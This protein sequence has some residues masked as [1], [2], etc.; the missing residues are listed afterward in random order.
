MINKIKLFLIIFFYIFTT[1]V[2]ASNLEKILINGNNRI[3]DDTIKMFSKIKIGE[4]INEI[5]LNNILKNLYETYYFED[6]SVQIENNNLIINVVEAKIIQDLN[7]KGIKSSKI[8]EEIRKNL[9][10]KPR[11]SFNNFLLIEDKRKIEN[12]LKNFGYY[13]SEVE[14]FITEIEDNKLNIDHEIT[15]GEKSKIKKISFIGNKI[16]KNNKLR[17]IIIS[18][19]YKFWKFISGKKFLN[20]EL[21]KLD[22]RLLKNFYLNKGYYNVEVNSSFAKMINN[23]EF[24]LIYNIDP[25]KKVYFNN[26]SLDIPKDFELK[27]FDEVTKILRKIKGEPY[28]LYTVEKILGLIEKITINEQYMSVKASVEEKITSDKLDLKFKIDETEKYYVK[29]INI[30]GNNVTQENV[31]RNQ[32][33]ID[34][35]DPFNSILQKKNNK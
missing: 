17:N 8:K 28:S 9:I 7:I 1:T 29:K 12:A 32:F 15:L 11:S 21:I 23:N 10:L 34:E 16:Y 30:Y 26:I 25:K 19:E 33:E 13:F 5:D 6:V 2:N 20:Q 27:N 22:Q 14:T 4:N 35:G 18:E 3:S 24:E 31:I